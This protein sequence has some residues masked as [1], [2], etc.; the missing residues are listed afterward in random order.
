MDEY[1]VTKKNIDALDKEPRLRFKLSQT[2]K[3]I[4]WSEFTLRG[5]N[6]DDM[7]KESKSILKK[8]EQLEVFANGD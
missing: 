4:R 8:L 3:G 2:M 6:V 5:N 7:V 1:E